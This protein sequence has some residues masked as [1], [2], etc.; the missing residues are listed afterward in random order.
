M[1]LLSRANFRLASKRNSFCCLSDLRF[2]SETCSA[3]LWHLGF[4]NAAWGTAKLQNGTSM[5]E[6]YLPI[7]RILA[8]SN[9]DTTSNTVFFKTY[10]SQLEGIIERPRD[11]TYGQNWWFL[12]PPCHHQLLKL[13]RALLLRSLNIL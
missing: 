11:R 12:L 10:N 4:S 8:N 5:E 3:H 9:K 2:S 6:T 7:T 1:D 13:V